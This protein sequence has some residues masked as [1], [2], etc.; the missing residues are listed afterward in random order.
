MGKI[1]PVRSELEFHRQPRGDAQDEVDAEYLA[2]E[3]RR[4]AP[5]RPVG[6]DIDRFHDD[7]HER[8]A[9]RQ[10]DEEKMVKRGQGELKPR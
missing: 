2:P 9:Q 1:G 8:Q 10:R 5:D 6:H 7:Q 4:R 3:A